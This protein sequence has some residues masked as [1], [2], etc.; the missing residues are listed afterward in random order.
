MATE[1]QKIAERIRAREALDVADRKRQR[2][3]IRQRIAD[4]RSWDEVQA[5]ASVSRPTLAKALA[6]E[7]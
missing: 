7:D 1:L 6:R 2:E 5:E 3:L 4:G